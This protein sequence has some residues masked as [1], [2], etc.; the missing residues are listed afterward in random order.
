MELIDGRNLPPEFFYTVE[1]DHAFYV[2][3]PTLCCCST[4][5]LKHRGLREGGD[6]SLR[7]VATLCCG[8]IEPERPGRVKRVL[9]SRGMSAVDGTKREKYL[10]I[11]I[12][13]ITED[14]AD[15]LCLCVHIYFLN[16]ARLHVRVA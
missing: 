8:R 13:G 9:M 11:E 7:E 5:G 14:G 15:T 12:G 6:G 4:G 3:H 2:L 16:F 10:D 1:T